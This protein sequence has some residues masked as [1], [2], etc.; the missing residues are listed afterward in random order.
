LRTAAI[1]LISGFTGIGFAVSSAHA[2]ALHGFCN[3]TQPAG[4]CVDN[5]TNV[6]LGNNSSN[7]GF[8]ISSGPR[9]GELFIDLLVPNKYSIP[10]SFTL[11]G[12]HGGAANNL[13][14]SAL[15]SL[16]STTAWTSGDLGTYLGFNP[17]SPSNPIGAFLPATQALD[18]T[19]TGFFVFQ[20]DIGTTKI[21]DNA[22]ATNGPL[23]DL[24]SGFSSDVGGYI[25]GFC[26]GCTS[27]VS[28]TAPSGALVVN[29]D[30]HRVPEPSTLIL[31]GSGL[32][33]LRFAARRFL[34]R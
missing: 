15:A 33:I 13:A 18:P 32:L 9:T 5:G 26:A 10:A 29:G 8:S 11:T 31:L 7:F 34:H 25:V 16:V 30:G 3:G 24:V 2:V 17:S 28:A 21:W 1:L 14:I 20:A 27:R 6:P 19:A 23:F 22:N 4:A 12:T